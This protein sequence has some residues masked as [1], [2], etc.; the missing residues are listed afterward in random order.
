[1]NRDDVIQ[2]TKDW[3]QLEAFRTNSLAKNLDQERWDV[4]NAARDLAYNRAK[5]TLIS[6][7]NQRQQDIENHANMVATIEELLQY[8]GE[9]D[10]CP[11][12]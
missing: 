4:L 10:P 3:I 5:E 8:Q 11:Q 12:P 1:M 6:Y 2:H 7:A 9:D